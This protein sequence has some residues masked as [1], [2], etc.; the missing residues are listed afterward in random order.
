VAG[1]DDGGD[2]SVVIRQISLVISG[3]LHRNMDMEQV[4]E[5]RQLSRCYK[6]IRHLGIFIECVAGL[7][8]AMLIVVFLCMITISS[9]GH[10]Y[11]GTPEDYFNEVFMRERN[12]S[13]KYRDFNGFFEHGHRGMTIAA[14]HA[15]TEEVDNFISQLKLQ[16]YGSNYGHYA[17]GGGLRALVSK[18]P[19]C[20]NVDLEKS[21]IYMGPIGG[22]IGSGVKMLLIR[23]PDNLVIIRFGWEF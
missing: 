6:I 21:E 16:D 20:A 19:I 9:C 3:A 18:L 12:I 23:G 1:A 4:K 10:E 11:K 2:A 5:K 22:T 14:F 8:W 15:N 17:R 7:L 13:I